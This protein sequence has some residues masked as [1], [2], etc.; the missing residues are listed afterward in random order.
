MASTLA[1][2]FEMSD[3]RVPIR[4]GRGRSFRARSGYAPGAWYWTCFASRR[5]S[6]VSIDG[7]QGA[8]I[9]YYLLYRLELI[10]VSISVWGF[11]GAVMHLAGGLL[12]VVGLVPPVSWCITPW[13]SQWH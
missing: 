6:I 3:E 8:L 10:P 9:F 13:L 1:K 7:Q 2:V 12:V 11:A 5:A 4:C